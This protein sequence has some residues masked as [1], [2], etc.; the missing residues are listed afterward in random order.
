M[1]DRYCVFHVSE[2]G[3]ETAEEAQAWIERQDNPKDYRVTAFKPDAIHVKCASDMKEI[4]IKHGRAL[5]RKQIKTPSQPSL[6]T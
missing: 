6:K 1:K 3:F 2:P 4:Y 5:E